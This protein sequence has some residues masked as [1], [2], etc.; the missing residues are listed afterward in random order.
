[1]PEP[2]S[3]RYPW[4]EMEVGDSF[5]F[6]EGIT[7]NAALN[8][9]KAQNRNGKKFVVRKTEEGIAAWRTA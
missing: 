2:M 7:Q 6:P 9:S 3:N 8:T 1:M 4:A 5:V